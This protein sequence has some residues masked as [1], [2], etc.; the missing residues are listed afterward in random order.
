MEKFRAESKMNP[1]LKKIRTEFVR[2]RT[3]LQS[4]LFKKNRADLENLV[5]RENSVPN[6]TGSVIWF[7]TIIHD[8]RKT[9]VLE[10]RQCGSKVS[11]QD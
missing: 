2:D 7:G 3:L 9:D 10:F 5:I 1:V 6:R 8:A 4:G 11:A